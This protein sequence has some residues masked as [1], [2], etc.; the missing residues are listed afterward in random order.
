MKKQ[1][2]IQFYQGKNLL[3]FKVNNLSD[4]LKAKTRLKA[5]NNAYW[6]VIRIGYTVISNTRI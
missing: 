6:H 4:A 5:D 1:H 3:S 2:Y